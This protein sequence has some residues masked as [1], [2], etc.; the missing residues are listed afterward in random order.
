MEFF[1]FQHISDA[2]RRQRQR[3][4]TTPTRCR[5]TIR[6][7]RLWLLG[8]P[9]SLQQTW[10]DS[11]CANQLSGSEMKT[12]FSA[13]TRASTWRKLWVWLAEAEKELG[14]GISDEAISQM[15]ANIAMTD[16]CFDVAAE[17]EKR[18]RHDVM[19]SV[20]A[21]GQVAP[22]AAGIIHWGATSC[23]VTDNA[24]L[25]FLRDALDLLLPKLATII[26]KLSQFAIQYKD[27]PTLGYTHYQPAQL[28]TVGRRAAQWVMDVSVQ[29]Q[30]IPQWH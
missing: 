13:R 19:A 9:V 29:K 24:D 12:I 18:R 21:Y 10:S 7:R 20:H 30:N 17:E 5:A 11:P 26:H 15:K 25:I 16:K 1:G 8:M 27:M 2:Q 3:P 14:L 22:A 28:I 23:Y 4:S 6:I